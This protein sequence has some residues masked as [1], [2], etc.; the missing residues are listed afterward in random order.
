ML[1]IEDDPALGALIAALCRLKQWNACCVT[2]GH[3]AI[4][5]LRRGNYD[6]IVLDLMLPR[7]NG[8]EVLAF[9]R[10]ERPSLLKRVVVIT[11]ASQRT[12]EAFDRAPIAALIHKPFELSDFLAAV[13]SAVSVEK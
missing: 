1:V 3:A 8:F 2:D 12:L 4:A 13:D 11:A 5:A 7:C 10:A 6:A 9:L